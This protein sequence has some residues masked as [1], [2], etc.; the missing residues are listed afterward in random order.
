VIMVQPRLQVR[1]TV[2]GDVQLQLVK[3]PSRRVRTEGEVHSYR[4]T[5]SRHFRLSAFFHARDT[6]QELAQ[7]M[8]RDGVLGVEF[9]DRAPLLLNSGQRRILALEPLQV[10][11]EQFPR[12]AGWGWFQSG[13]GGQ[14]AGQAISAPVGSVKPALAAASVK[15]QIV[16]LPRLQRGVVVLGAVP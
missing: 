6:E 1:A 8:I 2:H 9:A 13:R 4:T 12:L 15:Q 5:R 14:P 16:E 7:L 11:A 3:T 10:G